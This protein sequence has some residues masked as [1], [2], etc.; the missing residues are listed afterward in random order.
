[1]QESEDAGAVV[2]HILPQQNLLWSIPG[3]LDKA[4]AW[5]LHMAALTIP[6]QLLSEEVTRNLCA[7]TVGL[8]GATPPLNSILDIQH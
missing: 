5:A 6:A 2:I 7:I 4:L 8:T 3:D 1:M